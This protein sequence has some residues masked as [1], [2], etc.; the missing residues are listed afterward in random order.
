VAAV[1]AVVGAPVTE[2]CASLAVCSSLLPRF[3]CSSPELQYF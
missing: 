3:C 1:A 2:W